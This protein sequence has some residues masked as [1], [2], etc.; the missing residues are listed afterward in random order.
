M[1]RPIIILEPS[2]MQIRSLRIV[3]LALLGLAFCLPSWGQSTGNWTLFGG[4]LLGSPSGFAAGAGVGFHLTPHVDFEPTIAFGR[5]AGAGL[6]SLDGS[7]LY[8]FH[9]SSTRVVPYVLGGVGLAEFGG[10][11]HGSPIV[12]FGARSPLHHGFYIR[13]E[14]R[15][16]G[17]GLS[18]FTIGISKSF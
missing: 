7:F 4:A 8:N 15:L 13:P 3:P 14:V 6:F 9:L 2:F 11:T 12:G 5:K 1:Q 17:N 18:R 16:A 10:T